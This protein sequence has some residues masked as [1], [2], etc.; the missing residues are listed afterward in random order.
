MKLGTTLIRVFAGFFS[1]FCFLYAEVKETHKIIDEWVTTER[2]ISEEES[3]WALEKNALIDLKQALS[4]EIFELN[5]KLKE[6][7]EEAVGAAKQRQDL[8]A[9]KDEAIRATASLHSPRRSAL[10]LS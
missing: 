3:D 2:L 7:E 9:R 8:L 4:A 6:S 1:V 10:S 5:S